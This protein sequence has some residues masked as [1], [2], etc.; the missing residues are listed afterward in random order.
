LYFWVQG[1]TTSIEQCLAQEHKMQGALAACFELGLLSRSRIKHSNPYVSISCLP[2]NCDTETWDT[3]H[4]NVRILMLAL[5]TPLIGTGILTCIPYK[6][7]KSAYKPSAP[8]G[9]SLNSSFYG[10]KQL[11]VFLLSLDGMP[12]H[13]KVIPSIKFAGTQLYT[14][15]ERGTVSKGSCLR[16]QHNVPSQEITP[17]YS[18]TLTMRPPCLPCSM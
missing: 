10:M 9:Q 12:V 3:R 7:V 4:V 16:T 11:G 1:I 5:Q 17:D 14:W 2:L 13:L 15:V 8:S 18:I 6:K